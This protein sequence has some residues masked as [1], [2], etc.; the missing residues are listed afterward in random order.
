MIWLSNP[1]SNEDE[2][3]VI[4]PSFV[5]YKPIVETS[6][7]IPVPLITKEENSFKLD[8]ETLKNAI[9]DKTKLLILPYPNNP[10][11]AVMRKGELEEIAAIVIKHNLL[12]FP[13]ENIQ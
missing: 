2:A 12:L 13:H 4:E 5:C 10:T 7:G 3:L 6:G 11:G 8:A 9:T 1:I